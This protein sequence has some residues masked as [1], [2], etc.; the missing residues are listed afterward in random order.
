M[1]GPV[2][3]RVEKITDLGHKLRVLGSGLH[4]SLHFFLEV[5]PSSADN[6]L[7]N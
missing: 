6:D 3:N 2:I 7:E 5:L 1:F 4:T